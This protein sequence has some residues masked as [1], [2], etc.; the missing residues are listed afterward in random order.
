M[1]ATRV[2]S[3]SRRAMGTRVPKRSPILSPITPPPTRA[4]KET[5]GQGTDF[6]YHIIAKNGGGPMVLVHKNP[7]KLSALPHDTERFSGRVLQHKNSFGYILDDKTKETLFYH[8][9]NVD[10]KGYIYLR[11]GQRI[12]YNLTKFG[13]RT[14]A[15]FVRPMVQKFRP[16]TEV[17]L[18][19]G[20]IIKPNVAQV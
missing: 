8:I 6:T 13:D 9:K 18:A 15:G 3:T 7:R 10:L 5:N 14:V 17:D 11:A 1:L 16:Q 2:F 19:T 20:A 4:K 12:T